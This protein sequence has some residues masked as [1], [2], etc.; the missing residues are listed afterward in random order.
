MQFA[1]GQINTLSHCFTTYSGHWKWVP[2]QK[3]WLNYPAGSVNKGDVHL[4]KHPHH[5][6]WKTSSF[7]KAATR[8]L[9]PCSKAYYSLLLLHVVLALKTGPSTKTL[10][11]PMIK[12]R[13]RT[14]K[15]SIWRQTHPRHCLWKVS[16][17]WTAGAQTLRSGLRCSQRHAF[18]PSLAPVQ[19]TIHLSCCS[20]PLGQDNDPFFLSGMWNITASCQST[21][22]HM[23]VEFLRGSGLASVTKQ[24]HRPWREGKVTKGPKAVCFIAS[25]LPIWNSFALVSD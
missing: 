24:K 3:T 9:C 25:A 23:H 15:T 4:E 19:D 17:S 21:V 22:H 10:A 13:E 14:K 11:Q 8:T 12:Q 20:C 2:E 1:H 18:Q 16:S 6:L 7:W 5:C